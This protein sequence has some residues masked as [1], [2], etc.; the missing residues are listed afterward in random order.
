MGEDARQRIGV[1]DVE[2]HREES[3]LYNASPD[4][5]PHQAGGLVNIQ[6]LHQS[7]AVRFRRFH[8]D[9]Q[10]GCHVF[11]RFSLGDQLEYL[12]LPGS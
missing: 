11:R 7:G 6:L 5:V 3:G 4:R 1:A 9:A 10:Q 8:T 12:P 2:K